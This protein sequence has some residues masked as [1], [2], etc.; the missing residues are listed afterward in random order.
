VRELRIVVSRHSAFYSP[1]IATVAAGFLERE[2]FSASYRP[3]APAE[4]AQDLLVREEADVI[5]SAVSSSWLLLERGEK[6]AGVHFAQINQ[7][8]GFFLVGRQRSPAFHWKMLEGRTL[9]AD[10]A[11]QPLAML[12]YAVHRQGTDWS[13]IRVV[14]A[15]TPE[16]I[17]DA[18]RRGEGDFAHLQGPAAQQLE[19]EGCGCVVA[20]VGEAMPAVAFSSLLAT[21]AFLAT[22]A[23]RAFLRAY[24]KARQWVRTTPA[25]EVA[26]CVK[27]FFEGF[28]LSALTAAIS[29]YQNL[30]C[31][32]GGL[33]IPRDLYEQALEVFLY[34]GAITRRWAYDEVVA[35]PEVPE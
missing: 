8:D 20:S 30:G 28:S 4:R 10:H 31:W 1:L 9:L 17:A 29:R 22:E 23:A 19:E 3:M 24:S 32:E 7:R 15:G 6:P 16:Q 14:D 13:R 26:S 18:F 21:R 33:A 11:A 35:P 34:A 5:Q 27:P 12:R 25:Q 2:G